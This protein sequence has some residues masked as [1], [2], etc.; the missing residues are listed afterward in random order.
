MKPEKKLLANTPDSNTVI[1][2]VAYNMGNLTTHKYVIV[3]ARGH[4]RL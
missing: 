3:Y 4:K 1:K 2:Q